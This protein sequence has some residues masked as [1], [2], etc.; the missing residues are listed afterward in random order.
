MPHFEKI[1]IVDIRSI[2]VSLFDQ[3]PFT[4]T[5]EVRTRVAISGETILVAMQKSPI[6]SLHFNTVSGCVLVLL[7]LIFNS[8]SV[9]AWETPITRK[10]DFTVQPLSLTRICNTKSIISMNGMFPGPTLYANEGDRILVN[11]T[12][13]GQ[14]NISIHWH[15][16]RQIL[17]AWAD[18]PAY[19]TQCPIQTGQS[20]MYNFTITKQSGTLFWH[21]HE[22]WLRGTVY[23]AIV[24]YPQKSYPFTFSN[25]EHVIL[26]GE[27]WKAN[28]EDVET[29][30]LQNGTGPAIADA[31][32]INGLPGPLYNC[33]S[34]DTYLLKVKPKRTYLLRIVNAALNSEL[35]FTV[36]K[37][38]LTVVEIDGDYTKPFNTTTILLT[39]GQS[40]NVLIN[41]DQPIGRY[42]MGASPYMSAVNV[43][44]QTVPTLAIFEYDTAP[45]STPPTMPTFPRSNDTNSTTQFVGSLRSL[46]D[47]QHLET[48]PQT[49]DKNLF[50]TVGLGLKPC[51]ANRTCQGPNGKNFTASVNN[52]S[53][54]LPHIAL[55]QSY[56]FNISNVFTRDFPDKTL[57]PFAYTSNPPNNLTPIQGTK[58]D[59]IPFNSNVQIVLQDTSLVGAENHP[60]HLHGFSF[61]IVGQGFGD[62][63]AGSANFNL[64]DP[65]R[66]NTIGVPVGGWAAIRFKADNPGVWYMHCHLEIHTTWGL[67]MAFIVQ[68][69]VGSNQTL[70]PPPPDLP[71]C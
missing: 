67:A 33:S 5:M 35:F 51:D 53:L 60:I 25:E 2:K 7:I 10:F 70:P 9:A 17:S 55:L 15:G 28:V 41:S 34:T 64:V 16:I 21:A 1:I 14:Y 50:F 37:H 13:R 48:I 56:Y 4:Q 54:I 8:A 47:P 44:F 42:Y 45:A 68:N 12:N 39:P 31:Y 36:A 11:V 59:V 62:F 63:N 65:P 61:Y 29:S 66:R 71:R 23:G 32:T 6:N 26:L 30:A 19:I 58:L 49:V 69:G 27:W 46:N 3:F 52:I 24:I 57:N 18:G 38:T 20:Y 40:T 43:P 22:T